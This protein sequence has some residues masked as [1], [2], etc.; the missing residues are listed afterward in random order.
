MLHR[1]Y[2]KNTHGDLSYCQSLARNTS[3][4]LIRQLILPIVVVVHL[5]QDQ[6]LPARSSSTLGPVSRFFFIGFHA[7]TTHSHCTFEL[8]SGRIPAIAEHTVVSS[9]RRFS[10]ASV[11]PENRVHGHK[12]TEIVGIDFTE[13]PKMLRKIAQTL[14]LLH[15]FSWISLPLIAR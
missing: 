9:S 4:T 10:L 6:K 13:N 3:R 7:L 14:A 15:S 1:K 2:A 11:F 5:S 12:H 8:F